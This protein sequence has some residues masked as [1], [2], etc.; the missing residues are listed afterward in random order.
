ML[1][2]RA[3]NSRCASLNRPSRSSG[4]VMTMVGRCRHR[5]ARV[6]CL[7]GHVLNPPAARRQGAD[8]ANYIDHWQRRADGPGAVFASI[9]SGAFRLTVKTW[10]SLWARMVTMPSTVVVSSLKLEHTTSLGKV[11]GI[12]RTTNTFQRQNDQAELRIVDG[13]EKLED[14]GP[15]GHFGQDIVAMLL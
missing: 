13:L 9:R 2:A 8:G 6:C 5:R 1:P 7:C 15:V 11:G 12:N 4:P 10:F 14:V 3:D